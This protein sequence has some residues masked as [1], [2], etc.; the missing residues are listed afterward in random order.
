[1]PESAEELQR[2]I[3]AELDKLKPPKRGKKQPKPRKVLLETSHA[4]YVRDPALLAYL[5]K[6]GERKG[7]DDG[8]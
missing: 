8:E 2:R 5:A 6:L 3:Q 1:M 4:R 7:L